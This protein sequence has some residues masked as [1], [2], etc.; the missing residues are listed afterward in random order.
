MPRVF[1]RTVLLLFLSSLPAAAGPVTLLSKADP[2]RPSGTA[3]GDS[4]AVGI[5]ADGRYV[6]LSSNADNLVPGM[7][8]AHAGNNLFLHDRIAGTTVL[9]NHAAGDPSTTGDAGAVSA[10]LSADGRWVAFTSTATNLV[11]GQV[12]GIIQNALTAPDVFLWDRDS[13][14]T[15]LVSHPPGQPATAAGSSQ[16]FFGQGISADG[17]RVV[18]GSQAPNLM[19]GQSDNSSSSDV[20]LYDR[21]TDTNTLVSHAAGSAT[22]AAGSGPLDG[23][24]SADGSW[25]AFASTATNLVAGQVDGNGGSDLF[26]YSQA[27]GTNVLVSHAAGAAATAANAK[28]VDPPGSVTPEMTLSADGSQIA[29]WSNATNLVAGQTDGNALAD[30]FLYDRAAGTNTLVSHSSAA[31]T[32]TGNGIG[33]EPHVSGDGRYV[34][35]VSTSSDLV[36]GDTNGWWDVFV[37]DRMAGTNLL[38]SRRDAGT[39]ANRYSFNPRISADGAWIGFGSTAGNLVAGQTGTTDGN[40]FLWSRASGAVTLVSRTPGSATTAAGGGSLLLSDDG[41]WLT[42]NSGAAL[43]NGIDDFNSLTDVFLVERAT[44]VTSLL[45]GRGGAV[46][47]AAGGHVAY[48]NGSVLS[49]D[50][51][52]IAFT[53]TAPNLLG[54]TADANGTTDVFLADRIAGTLKLVSHTSGSPTVAGDGLSDSPVISGDGSAV[55]YWSSATNLISGPGSSLFS[56]EL[57]LYDRTTGANILVSHDPASASTPVSGGVSQSGY[58]AVSGDGRWIAYAYTG[59]LVTGQVDS[60]GGGDIFLFDRTTGTNILVSHASSSSVQAANGTS[61]APS[62]SADGR[63]IAFTSSASNLV[64]G[65]AGAGGVFLFDQVTGTTTQ[66]STSGAAPPVISADG[67]WVLF[68]SSAANVVPSQVDTNGATDVFLWDRVSGSTLLVSH[69]PAS[70]VTAGNAKSDL[71]GFLTG[72]AGNPPAL[73]ADGRW[74][75]FY[76]EATNLVS[77][78]TGNAGGVYLFD[79]VAGTVTLVSRSASSPTANSYSDSPALSAD[80]R[81]VAFVSPFENFVPGEISLSPGINY[82]L[83]DRIA[84]TTALVSHIPASETTARGTGLPENEEPAR[85]SADGAWV[86]FA[87]PSTAL[88]AGDHD[89]TRD[90]FLYANLSPGRDFF[91]VTPCRI[92]DTRQVA[93]SPALTSGLR[94]IVLAAGTCGIPA[95]ARAIAVNLTVVQPSAAGYLALHAGDTAPDATSSLNFSTGQTL[96]NNAVVPLAFD[97]SGTLAVTPLVAGNGTVHLILDVSGYFE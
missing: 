57:Y 13:G 79:R 59:S 49:N 10:A 67:R 30:I 95:T 48:Y 37:Y 87:S 92:L 31:A 61:S 69:T 81:F 51:R 28:S 36:A 17:N 91:T 38:V 84:G 74:V 29:Y 96:A 94:R 20:F 93:Q 72:F 90:A 44:G 35:Y 6:L 23:I 21:A 88:A 22:T 16:T 56:G 2:D 33:W 86:A 78:Q 97:G 45:T 50:G 4:Q 25:V 27:T 11:A 12:E 73:S 64:T 42:V 85:I 63:Y 34:A 7:T 39:P 1:L 53:S 65:Q 32:T 71:G 46:S 52:F 19:A 76:S 89:G 70:M 55:V 41:S 62:I 5:S 68:A 80:G 83:Y 8:A 18:F 77:G 75:A 66:V 15:S 43:V 3:G 26:L 47:A 14:L 60:N 24:L 82:F 58:Y 9:V 40:A 54:V